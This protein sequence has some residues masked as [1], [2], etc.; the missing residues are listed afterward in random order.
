M[1]SHPPTRTS[2]DMPIDHLL[3]R[4]RVQLRELA[5]FRDRRR[6]TLGPARFRDADGSASTVAVGDP[7]PSRSWPV[8]FRFEVAVPG[9]WQGE[10]G[11]RAT[12]D[13]LELRLDPGGEG[14]LTVAG[15][16]VGGLNPYHR[17]YDVPNDA[18]AKFEVRIEAVPKAPFSVEIPHPRLEQAQLVLPDQDVRA[19]HLDLAATYDAAT[20][21]RGHRPDIAELLADAVAETLAGLDLPRAPTDAYLARLAQE[22]ANRDQVATVWEEWTFDA[23]PVSLSE[24]QRA[25]LAGA[26]GE[27]AER[28]DRIRERYGSEGELWLSGHAHLDLAW[29]WPLEETRRK[30]QRTFRTVLTLMDRYPEWSFNQS[31]AQLYAYL[32]EDDPDAFEA[33]RER[34]AEGRW[35]VV[36]GMWVEP[37][38]N[39][40]S[41]ESWARQLL[42]GQRWLHEHLGQ[43]ATVA[44]LPD[45]FGYA[46]NMPQLLRQAGME[47]FFTTKLNWSETNEFP[48]DLYRWEGLDGSSVLAHSFHNQ[49]RNYSGLL[50]AEDTTDVWRRFRS[51][52]H[53][54]AS[55]FTFGWG[56]GGGGPTAEMLERGARQARMPGLPRLLHARVDA[57]YD[58]VEREVDVDRLPVWVGEK[59]LEFH[60][61]TYT[62][63][64]EIKRLHRRLEHDLVEA[65][66]AAA[67]HWWLA[68]GPYPRAALGEAW[69]ILLRNQF[70]DIL[71]GSSVRTVNEEAVDE[72]TR[73]W[74]SACDL[75]D[76]ALS[77]LSA[78]S[79]SGRTAAGPSADAVVVWNLSSDDRPLR[80][81][82]PA[83]VRAVAHDGTRL[84]VQEVDGRPWVNAPD[85]TVPAVG[86]LALEIVDA[87]PASD[88]VAPGAPMLVAAADRL[89]NE[90]LRVDI[91]PDGTFRLHDKTR[92]RAVIADGGNRLWAHPDLPRDFEAWEIDAD[93]RAAGTTLEV[94]EAAAVV[95]Q[96]PCTVAVRVVRS[97]AGFAVAQTYR[98]WAGARRLEIAT[99]V[100]Q[101]GRRHL[102]RASFPTT[103]RHP[104]AT[105]ETAYG[106][107]ER[108]THR[109]TPWDAAQFEV[110]GLRWADLSEPG[111]GV[112]LVTDAKYGYAAHGSELSLTLL[113]GPVYPDPYAD[114]GEHRFV[115]AIAPHD[116]DWRHDTVAQAH[117]LN[118]PLR[119]HGVAK[120]DGAGGLPEA[121]SF[122]RATGVT[123]R[124]SALKR[125]ESDDVLIA[126][127]YE[128]H[129]ARG[130]LDV[131]ADGAPP[132]FRTRL[133]EDERRPVEG[134]LE[135]GPFEV[136]TVGF[137]R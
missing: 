29:L 62:T 76:D 71:P 109:N 108:P 17:A 97:G 95:E 63:Q 88:G 28:L 78:W 51:K 27:L 46:G 21:L 58:M 7:W 31:M 54:K 103:V 132:S 129:G 118:T 66:A 56:D 73:A 1:S 122:V 39:L 14:L 91:L 19:L 45:T 13:R 112:S 16:I 69:T 104:T 15:R 48:Y 6:T 49:K 96:G 41:G 126:R 101:S 5:S 119:A 3:A 86:C 4:L 65:E 74:R 87:E 81:A 18:G 111:C 33:V 89:E 84:A 55:L 93:V 32:R 36:G 82:L 20:H 22:P 34:V 50:G 123:C 107:V 47:R 77:A 125:A 75:R 116:G 113:R 135:I 8:T 85:V 2:R 94:A 121:R 106:A 102:L 57:Y 99:T 80:A 25:S 61:G 10:D 67:L 117:A 120:R 130:R 11:G 64:A 127:W 40:L 43:R 110:P 134:A 26:R 100:R 98:L 133:L 115:M 90:H 70:H 79:T 131:E 137:E 128:P 72:M 42:V 83:G 60:R 53:A 52:R 68:D 37:D 38:G 44:W 23:E 92:D 12:H 114:E 24:A 124:L 35:E 30:G 59:Y 9:A 105:F 136:V